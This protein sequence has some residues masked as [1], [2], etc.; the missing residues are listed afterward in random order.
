MLDMTVLADILQAA[1]RLIMLPTWRKNPYDRPAGLYAP[2]A[3]VAAAGAAGDLRVL[4]AAPEPAADHSAAARLPPP[5][6]RAH[7]HDAGPPHRLPGAGPGDPQPLAF[8]HQRVRSAACLPRRPGDRAL[9][10]LGP[11]AP[12]LAGERRHRHRGFR[13]LR[14]ALWAHWCVDEPADDRAPATR[15]LRLPSSPHQGA[16]PP[17][18]AELEPRGRHGCRC[19]VMT[20]D[21]VVLL[22]FE[23]D[24][25]DR[26]TPASSG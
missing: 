26:A 12:L 20:V 8:P 6:A 18:R 25:L 2:S 17:G 15:H 23:I 24:A 14:S 19:G 13:R 9:S 11:S 7:H 16:P 21:A 4:R 3:A 5:H 22:G 1:H 10:S